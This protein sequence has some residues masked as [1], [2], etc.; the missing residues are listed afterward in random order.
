[1]TYITIYLYKHTNVLL[2]SNMANDLQKYLLYC[3]ENNKLPKDTEYIS[4]H[5]AITWDFIQQNPEIKWDFEWVSMNP[6]ISFSIVDNNPNYDWDYQELS[7]HLDLTWDYILK[8]RD[9]DWDWAYIFNYLEITPT[10]IQDNPLIPWEYEILATNKSIT[11]E[12]VKINSH[13]HVESYDSINNTAIK[14][15]QDPPKYNIWFC[16]L[17]QS[18]PNIKWKDIQEMPYHNYDEISINPNITIDIIRAYPEKPWNFSR[19]SQN[20]SVSGD[21]VDANPDIPWDYLHLSQNYNITPDYII[22]NIDKPWDFDSICMYLNKSFELIKLKSD[23]DWPYEEIFADENIIFDIPELN[24]NEK[25]INQAYNGL[26]QNPNITID[27]LKKSNIPIN[28]KYLKYNPNLTYQDIIDYNISLDSLLEAHNMLSFN[29]T[30]YNR[31][32]N[33]LLKTSHFIISDLTTIIKL[34][35]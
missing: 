33:E 13:I 18:N 2:T 15:A 9:K 17:L 31:L 29:D 21:I 7:R 14:W 19:F 23:Y 11:W 24:T 12:I 8:N 16:E 30:V 10:L 5:E 3:I 27:M 1:M 28:I 32:I 26:Q 6:N 25:W 20:K 34:Y 4:S 22:K 35:V